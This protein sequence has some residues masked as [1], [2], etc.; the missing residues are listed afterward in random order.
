MIIFP[1]VEFLGLAEDRV[2]RPI[3]PLIFKANG[4]E[5]RSYS[6][7]DSGADYSILPIEIASKFKFDLGNEPRYN[8]LGA[9]GNS[10]TIYKSPIEIEHIIKQ[11]GFREIKWKST[12]FFAESGSTILLGQNGFL[13]QFKIILNGK[14][15][16]VEIIQ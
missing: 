11:Q 1:Y 10:F 3:I 5:F 12:V 8:I 4:E 15:K 16:K 7:I 9:G 6:L 2:F 14:N 13:N